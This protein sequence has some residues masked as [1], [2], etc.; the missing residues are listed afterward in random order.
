MS[1]Q[2][3][4]EE[5][6]R[7]ADGKSG[8]LDLSPPKV[9]GA[10]LASVTAAF[11]GSRLGV[12]GT[13]VGAGLT[14]VVITVGG[15]LYQ[16]SFESAKEKAV[17]VAA[18]ARKRQQR[19]EVI[20]YVST[21]DKQVTRRI[22]LSPGM[23][24]PGGER[25]V[26][27]PDTDRGPDTDDTTRVLHPTTPSVNKR[28]QRVRWAMVA[29]SCALVFAL[30]MLVVTAFE[31]V[32][33]RPL[34]GG[35]GGTTIGQVLHRDP[36]PQHVIPE[37]TVVPE[38]TRSREPQPTQQVQPSQQPPVQPTTPTPTTTVE[39]TPAPTTQQTPPPESQV[40]EP[41]ETTGAPWIVPHNPSD[42]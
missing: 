8:K 36:P 11:L 23:H 16:R 10:A 39:P 40:V 14:S 31:G 25:V 22:H 20:R 17:L 19:T 28:R 4:E 21:E 29:A 35:G 3:D 2:G 24:W 33:G 41:D 27:S 32:T 6:K 34:S 13:V 12:A 7:D 37:R 30:S 15:A 42:R 9:A 38:P 1:R 26:D 5:K 18:K